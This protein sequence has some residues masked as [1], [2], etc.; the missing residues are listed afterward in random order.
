MKYLNYKINST[1]A[2]NGES[3]KIYVVLGQ[4]PSDYNWERLKYFPTLDKAKEYLRSL[5]LSP[6]QRVYGPD[7]YGITLYPT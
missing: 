1:W 6:R 2:M 5:N 7:G 3:I 4:K